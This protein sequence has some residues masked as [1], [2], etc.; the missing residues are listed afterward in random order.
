MYNIPIVK[1]APTPLQRLIGGAQSGIQSGLNIANALRQAETARRQAAF[2]EKLRPLQL[3]KMQTEISEMPSLLDIKRMQAQTASQA[4]NPWY[5]AATAYSHLTPTEKETLNVYNPGIGRKILRN[6]EPGLFPQLPKQTP[7]NPHDPTQTIGPDA[8]QDRLRT[9]AQ[10]KQNMGGSDP[11]TYKRFSAAVAAE[12]VLN[13]PRIERV[14]KNAS[15]YAGAMG[16]G[17]AFWDSLKK[18]KPKAYSD[19]FEFGNIL[20]QNEANIMR[21]IE[22]L[23]V[24][25][26]QMNELKDML[27]KATNSWRSNPRFALDQFNRLKKEIS[28]LGKGLSRAS[29]PLYPGVLEKQTGVTWDTPDL[30]MQQPAQ[31]EVPSFENKEQFQGWYQSLNPQQQ[32]QVKSQLGK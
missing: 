10:I 1:P 19:Y 24:R 30:Q 13:D 6:V 12:N 11:A 15:L 29:Q 5:R 27:T 4:Q 14:V 25:A 2:Q 26:S 7:Q 8:Y 31:V 23:S 17:Q 28:S 20:A 18:D 22:G 21:N 32:Q 9:T 3:Q 16:K